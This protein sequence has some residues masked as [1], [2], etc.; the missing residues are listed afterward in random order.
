M[1]NKAKC[2]YSYLE[3]HLTYI[4]VDCK[5][6]DIDLQKK[7]SR[8]CHVSGFMHIHIHICTFM[9]IY[10][11]IYTYIYIYVHAYILTQIYICIHTYT[12]E[13]VCTRMRMCPVQLQIG[14]ASSVFLHC[15]CAAMCC[16]A[17]CCS[18]EQNSEALCCTYAS[19]SA[20]V[21]S[22]ATTNPLNVNLSD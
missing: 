3:H 15:K 14:A 19:I 17:V 18:V 21:G 11:H 6:Q 12:Y 2:T 5:Y 8:H 20:R 9:Q 10:V 13:F 1:R 4:F 22:A 7:K 16:S